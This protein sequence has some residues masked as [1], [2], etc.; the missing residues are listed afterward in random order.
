MRI[1]L[2][3]TNPTRSLV[4]ALSGLRTIL[5]RGGHDVGVSW[6]ERLDDAHGERR[7]AYDGA[8]L[9]GAD[10][11]IHACLPGELRLPVEVRAAREA[12]RPVL[13]YEPGAG[14]TAAAGEATLG[15]GRLED[16]TTAIA[17]AAAESVKG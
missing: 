5:I 3:C 14:E 4:I 8:A 12:G 1:H 13:R 10:V 2:T 17:R 7:L 6:P 11:V 16:V 15:V 9:A